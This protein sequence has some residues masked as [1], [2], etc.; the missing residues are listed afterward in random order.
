MLEDILLL[1]N[2]GPIILCLLAGPFSDRWDC[3]I[4]SFDTLA[5][6]RRYSSLNQFCAQVWPETTTFTLL[7]GNESD[8]CWIWSSCYHRSHTQVSHSFKVLATL[9]ISLRLP[10]FYYML[11]SLGISLGGQF[12]VFFQVFLIGCCDSGRNLWSQQI[13]VSPSMSDVLCL[14]ERLLRQ[15]ARRQSKVY[16]VKLC[17][18][19]RTPGYYA[20]SSTNLERIHSREMQYLF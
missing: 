1:E 15:P 17:A 9:S 4:T 14:H 19:S 20:N 16:K 18:I 8:L 10:S 11:P 5:D 6:L 2:V 13:K 7:L 3:L 12:F